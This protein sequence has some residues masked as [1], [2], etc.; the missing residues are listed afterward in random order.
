MRWGDIG[1]KE[2]EGVL[3]GYRAGRVGCGDVIGGGLEQD[4]GCVGVKNGTQ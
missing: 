1:L 2:R 3:R 4:Y